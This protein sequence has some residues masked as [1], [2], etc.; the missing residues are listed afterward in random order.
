MIKKDKVFR[1]LVN[2]KFEEF[3]NNYFIINNKFLRKNKGTLMLLSHLNTFKYFLEK[4]K[5]KEKEKRNIQRK[6]LKNI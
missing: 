4:E 5:K 3:Y 2:L 1:K 6:K